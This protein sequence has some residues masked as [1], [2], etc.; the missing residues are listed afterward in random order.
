MF[1]RG[2]RDAS[3]RRRR[4]GTRSN[5]PW[6]ARQCSCRSGWRSRSSRAPTTPACRSGARSRGVPDATAAGDRHRVFD[7]REGRRG[8]RGR[9]RAARGT[10]SSCGRRVRSRQLRI[11]GAQWMRR[12]E[13]GEYIGRDHRAHVV[14]SDGGPDDGQH[15]PGDHEEEAD[16]PGKGK[17]GGDAPPSPCDGD[18]R[19][20][21]CRSLGFERMATRSATST[22][23]R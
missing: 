3:G 5:R 10:W 12:A 4:R 15:Q 8:P 21:Q 16:A 7:A 14:R 2:P 17:R 18:R 6:A 11:L 23:S 1:V 9:C 13:R 20:A 22:S 19:R